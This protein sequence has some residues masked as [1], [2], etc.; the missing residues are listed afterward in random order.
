MS[1][2]LKRRSPAAQLQAMQCE[3]PD[4][5]GEKLANGALVWKGPLKPQAKIYSVFILW[6]PDIMSLPY[7][8][9]DDPPLRPRPGGTFEEI[10]HL[11]FFKEKPAQS[12]LCLFDPEG[13]E[14]SPVDLIAET[15]VRWAS[16]WLNYYELWHLT[17][18]WLAPGVGYESIAHVRAAEARAVKELLADVH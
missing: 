11:I 8:T 4:F 10:P 13:K 18:E 1:S 17:G 15:T 12:G 6:K 14:W 7:V 16:E 3:W 5:T 9:I 2:A